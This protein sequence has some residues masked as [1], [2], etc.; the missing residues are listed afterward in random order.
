MS[1]DDCPAVAPPE[2]SD[3]IHIFRGGA[4][5]L[6]NLHVCPE[7]CTWV[8]PHTVYDSIE[9]EFQ[10]NK[11]QSHGLEKEADTLLT[12]ATPIDIMYWSWELI[13]QDNETWQKQELMAME[14]SCRNKFNNCSHARHVLLQARSEL[15]EGTSNLKWGSGLDVQRT[16]E[17]HPDYWPGENNMGKIL[18]KIWKDFEAE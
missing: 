5:P 12:L 6:S 16:K 2:V 14:F 17:C 4:D 10:H 15:V 1:S 8:T 3:S 9:K 18:S 7:G 13:P 11:V